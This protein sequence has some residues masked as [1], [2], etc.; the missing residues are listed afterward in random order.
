MIACVNL[1]V[2]INVIH[3]SSICSNVCI[4]YV[5][6][7]ALANLSMYERIYL[8]LM[9]KGKLYLIMNAYVNISR[10]SIFLL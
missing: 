2:C 7:Y 3:S 8:L 9:C 4:L 1:Y 5:Y 10:T 6:I